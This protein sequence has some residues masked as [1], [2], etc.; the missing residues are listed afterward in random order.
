VLQ[1]G[2]GGFGPA[3]IEAWRRLGFGSSLVVADP[4]AAA[5]ARAAGFGLPDDRLVADHRDVLERADVVDVVAPTD[6]H[7]EIC[8]AALEAGKDV[9]CEKPLTLD[10]A[11]ARAIADA[12]AAGGR[13]LQVG[14]YFRHHPLA[15]YAKARLAE[16]ALGDLRVVSASFTGFKRARSDSGA[17]GNDA[18]HF[19]DLLRWLTGEAP[20]EVYAITRDHFGRGFDDLALVL[21]THPSGLVAR[22]E[23]GY[24]QPG[25]WAN[26]IVPGAQATKEVTVSG[27]LGAIE[28]DFHS[29]RL[30]WHRVRHERHA[31]GLF[32]PLFGDA[33]MPHHTPMS[34]VEIVASQL[35]TFLGHVAGRTTPEADVRRCGVAMAELYAAIVES[36]RHHRPVALT[37]SEDG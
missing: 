3:H 31:D 12:V 11:G 23:A 4:D 22:I 6:R 7:V 20:S 8:L 9:F 19:L 30:I 26:T 10:L 16:G 24:I 17:L 25:R 21:L 15:R 5:R 28:I 13:V 32:R 35:E 2:F 37:R 1:V 36:A 14:Y 27:A 33:L 29:E 34:P 18:I